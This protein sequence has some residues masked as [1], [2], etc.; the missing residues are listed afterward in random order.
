MRTR[1]YRNIVLAVALATIASAAAA[2]SSVTLYGTVDAGVLYQN[3]SVTGQGQQ[4]QLATGGVNPSVWGLKGTEDLG[5]GMA[6]TFALESYFASNNGTLMTSP[7]YQ[8]QIFRR[9]SNV[10]LTTPYGTLTL[11]KMY[12]PAILAAI[13]TEPREFAENLSNLY[14]WAYNQLAAPGNALGAGTNPG[15]DVGVFIGNALQYSNTLGPV[16]FGAAYSF[17]GVPGSMRKG[18]EIS[19]GVT[20]TGPVIASAAY[21]QVADSVSGE[22]V[23]RLW[24]VGV[25][26][27]YGPV[28]GKLNYFDVIDRA[29]DGGDIS[30]VTSISPGVTYQWSASNVAGLAGYY[31]RYRGGHNSTTRSLV[32]SN[33]FS[34]SKRTML[35]AQVAYVDA[36]AVGTID[37]LESLK[38][39][40]VAGGTEPGANTVLVN[41]GIVHHF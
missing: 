2:Q 21:Q 12:S 16:W 28:T 24:S 37:P 5:G 9:Q 14:T 6:A 29:I 35:Y 27:S 15:N 7:G 34:L 40:I 3:R 32:L 17:G 26:K 25:A 33:D 38:T 36:G 30:H 22:N 11:G 23:S 19:L 8:T 20:Y 31:N 4:V 39:S 18:N 41:V 10:G 13:V 1:R